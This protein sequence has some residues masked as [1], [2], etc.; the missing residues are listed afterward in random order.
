M[1]IKCNIKYVISIIILMMVVLVSKSVYA[2]NL[3]GVDTTE[4]TAQYKIWYS[5]KEEEKAKYLQ[6][7]AYPIKFDP[8]YLNGN[9]GATAKA[10]ATIP[11][12]YNL[13]G[14]IDIEVKNQGKTNACWAFSMLTVLE[15]NIAK[16]TGEMS[17]EFSERHMEYAT[18]KTFADGV[19]K[20]AFSREVGAGGNAFVALGYAT[21]GTGIVKSSDMPFED[22]ENKLKLSAINKEP[23]VKVNDAKIFTS[24]YKY[25]DPTTSKTVVYDGAT[26]KYSDTEVTAV[27]NHIKQ[28]IMENGALFAFTYANNPDYYNNSDIFKATAYYCDSKSAI[29]DHAITIVGWDDTYAVTNFNSNHRPNNPGAYVVLNSYGNTVMDKGYYYISYEDALIESSV[30]GISDSEK[31]NYDNIYQNDFY[32]YTNEYSLDNQSVLYAANVFTRNTDKVEK[33]EEVV[34]C[35]PITTNIE[36]Y[37][38]PSD[39]SLEK[40]KLVKASLEKSTITETYN[41]IKLINPIELTGD[42]FAIVVK[43]NV[44]DGEASIGMEVNYKTVLGQSTMFDCITAKAGESFLS[45]DSNKWIDLN[46]I[47]KDTNVCIK[48]ITSIKVGAGNQIEINTNNNQQINNNNGNS[49]NQGT[50]IQI[51]NNT[52]SDDTTSKNKIPNAGT[53]RFGVIVLIL[54]STLVVS[55][56]KTKKYKMVK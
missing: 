17:E 10:K 21:N 55:G 45:L 36:V 4:Y 24:L 44:P 22:N 13:N 2:E 35:V 54:V 34:V 29:P 33:L 23:V 46:T 39:S 20:I 19:N 8:S 43:Y 11:A 53:I 48:G 6:P 50:N 12:T 28:Y 9:N 42:E 26:T 18:A 7:F 1:K 31:I 38:N 37:V 56:Y 40:G 27:R 30:V 14:D 41:T 47:Y 3:N 32:G 49:N 16:R 51:E 25:K 52:N 5:L 15:S